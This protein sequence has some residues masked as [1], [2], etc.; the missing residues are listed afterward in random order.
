MI[1]LKEEEITANKFAEVIKLALEGKEKKDKPGTTTQLV[2][3]RF[4]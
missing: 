1:R 3:P 4:P 2:K